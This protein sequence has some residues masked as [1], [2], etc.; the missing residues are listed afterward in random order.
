MDDTNLCFCN[1]MS[2]KFDN[3]EI[4]FTNCSFDVIETNT[5]SSFAFSHAAAASTCHILHTCTHSHTNSYYKNT[6]HSFIF[7]L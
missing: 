6:F 2:G 5:N 3:G 1:S 7:N 4:A